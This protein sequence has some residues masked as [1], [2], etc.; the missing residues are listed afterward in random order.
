MKPRD[1][2]WGHQLDLDFAI[3]A[4]SLRNTGVVTEHI[5]VTQFHFYSPGD[6]WKVIRVVEGVR[7]SSRQR[8]NFAQKARAEPFFQG[9]EI[10][11][12]YANRKDQPVCLFD[13]RFDIILGVAAPIVTT[14]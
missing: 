8:A 1:P 11:I 5:L 3:P 13:Q 14:V 7:G 6:L 4:I 2:A 9:R 12:K 10:P